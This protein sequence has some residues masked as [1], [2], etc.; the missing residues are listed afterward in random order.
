[1]KTV[2]SGKSG[3]MWLLAFQ[4]LQHRQAHWKEIRINVEGQ[5]TICRCGGKTGWR[6][7]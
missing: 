6:D 1:M 5:F 2:A 7:K 4:S 3:K